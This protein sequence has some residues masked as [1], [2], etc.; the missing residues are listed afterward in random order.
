MFLLTGCDASADVVATYD[1]LISQ[2]VM[3]ASTDGWFRVEDL[4]PAE[5]APEVYFLTGPEGQHLRVFRHKGKWLVANAADFSAW[6]NRWPHPTPPTAPSRELFKATG[7]E[8][9][10]VWKGVGYRIKGWCGAWTHIVV[11]R[12]KGLEVFGRA[13]RRNLLAA[14]EERAPVPPC[15]RQAI[16]LI[17]EGVVLFIDDPQV[18]LAKLEFRRIERARFKLPSKVL[19]RAELF[20]LL[21]ADLPAISAPVPTHR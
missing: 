16:D 17:G 19:S 7:E 5:K 11:M 9:V 13:L 8:T 18:K 20:A 21:G 14:A 15:E 4:R 3:E 6:L 12:G 1:T 10:G 2:R